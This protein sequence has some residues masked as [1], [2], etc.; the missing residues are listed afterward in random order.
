MTATPTLPPTSPPTEPAEVYIYFQLD[1]SGSVRMANGECIAEAGKPCWTL[2]GDFVEDTMREM[3]LRMPRTSIYVFLSTFSCTQPK[4]K[5]LPREPRN[6]ILTSP[7]WARYQDPNY[8]RAINKLRAQRANGGTCPSLGA[9]KILGAARVAARPSLY[10]IVTD[11]RVQA[12]DENRY[13]EAMRGINALFRRRMPDQG[14]AVV[15]AATIGRSVPDRQLAAHISSDCV[16]PVPTF[17]GLRKAAHEMAAAMAPMVVPIS[18]EK[19]AEYEQD[20]TDSPLA[21]PQ[22]THLP[23]PRPSAVLT[24]GPTRFPSIMPTSAMT[25]ATQRPSHPLRVNGSVGVVPEEPLEENQ[26]DQSNLVYL[27]L[28]P[29][30]L[31]VVAVASLLFA[32]RK[33]RGELPAQQSGVIQAMGF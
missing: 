30:V 9:R 16:F 20:A 27:W 21:T 19:P 11:G 22:P 4:N 3:Q 23:T 26:G 24:L 8:E 18:K 2:V 25:L 15:C 17:G 12:S 29:P 1:K 32:Y 14:D 13:R 6:A 10:M 5:K 28:I 7:R 31:A 33:K